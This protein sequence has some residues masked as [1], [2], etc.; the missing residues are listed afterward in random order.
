LVAE[1]RV[2]PVGVAGDDVVQYLVRGGSE[3]NAV[4]VAP[5]TPPRLQADVAVLDEAA[6]PGVDD[7]AAGDGGGRLVEADDA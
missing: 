2:D 7:D 3:K 1:K 4:A 5:G 6:G